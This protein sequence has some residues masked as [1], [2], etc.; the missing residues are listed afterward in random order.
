M[1]KELKDSE[2]DK[3]QCRR[4]I[5]GK[6]LTE[7]IGVLKALGTN[8]KNFKASLSHLGSQRMDSKVQNQRGIAEIYLTFRITFMCKD[9]TST[10]IASLIPTR[11]NRTVFLF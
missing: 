11:T 2:S 9:E 10:R 5:D 1:K 6:K 4:E 7:K 8:Q 3:T